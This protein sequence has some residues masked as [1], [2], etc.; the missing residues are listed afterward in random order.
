MIFVDTWVWL[1]F[2]QD[3]KKRDECKD[4][5]LSNEN[6]VIDP[7]VLMEIKHKTAKRFG[8]TKSE[9]ILLTIES[10]KNVKIIPLFSKT[11]TFAADLRLKHYGPLL[12]YADCV[13][14]AIAISTKCKRLY[15][16]DPDFKNIKELEVVIV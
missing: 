11:A 3:G 7:L 14:L 4:I 13:H 6:I 1:E 2:F 8:I 9:D 10:F 5:L 15:S 16:G 12:S